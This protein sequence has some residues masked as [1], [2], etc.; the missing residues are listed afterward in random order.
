M[1]VLQ[2]AHIQPYAEQGPNRTSNGLLLRADLHILLDQGYL[3]LTKDFKVEVSRKIKEEYENGRDYYA[4]HGQQ[5]RILPP[6]RIDR[7]S[8]EFIE[9][10]NQN[11]FVS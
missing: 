10:H 9:W 3:T 7:P 1:P 6:H 2:A 4:M 11:I 5:L 8:Q